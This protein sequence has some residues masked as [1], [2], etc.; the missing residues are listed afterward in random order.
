MEIGSKPVT[1]NKRKEFLGA[2]HYER[3]GEG[4]RRY[5]NRYNQ[6][7]LATLVFILD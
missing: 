2:A 4:H 5:A 1:R 7:Q 6:E 3:A